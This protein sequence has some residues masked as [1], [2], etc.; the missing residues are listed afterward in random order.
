VTDEDARKLPNGIYL[1]HFYGGGQTL[2][3][4]GKSGD[5]SSWLACVTWNN[6]DASVWD[7]VERAEIL[8]TPIETG[9]QRD[10]IAI[11][12]ISQQA[13]VILACQPLEPIDAGTMDPAIGVRVF[14]ALV[15]V[16]ARVR[17]LAGLVRELAVQLGANHED[18]NQ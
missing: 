2:A 16:D 5:G 13:A 12:R 4:V 7:L 15:N 8:F 18:P 6:P 11:A 9:A 3:A 17:S 10:A 1:I 14:D